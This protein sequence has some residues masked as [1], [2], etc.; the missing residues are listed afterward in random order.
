MNLYADG[1]TFVKY[2][3]IKIRRN[4]FILYFD[5]APIL[6]EIQVSFLGLNWDL[7]FRKSLGL[8]LFDF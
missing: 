5:R 3:I 8:L 1:L 2:D 6:S 4:I 7:K